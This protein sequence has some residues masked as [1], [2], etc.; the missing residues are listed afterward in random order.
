MQRLKPYRD[1]AKGFSDY[2][3]YAALIDDGIILCKDGSLLAGF[4]Y[5]GPDI[6]SRTMAQREDLS[7]RVHTAFSRLGSGW[8][9][10]IQSIHIETVTYPAPEQSFFPDPISRLVDDERRRQFEAEGQHFESEKSLVIQYTPPLR[11]NRRLMQLV[12][13]DASSSHA[14]MA[15]E[16]IRQFVRDLQNFEDLISDGLHLRRMTSFEVCDAEGRPHLCDELVNHLNYHIDQDT[17]ALII[18]DDGAYLDTVLGVKDF[19]KGPP[20]QLGEHFIACVAIRGFPEQTL[21]QVLYALDQL[22]IPYRWSTRVIHLDRQEAL[23]VLDAYR[24]KWAQRIHGWLAQTFKALRGRVNRDAVDMTEE[25]E[26]SIKIAESGEYSYVYH[27]PLVVLVDKDLEVLSENARKVYRT[28]NHLGFAAWIEGINTAAAWHGSLP[29]H[30]LPNVRRP[31]VHTGNLADLLPLSSVWAG[32]PVHPNPMYPPGSP[33]LMYAAT[34][35]A[36]PFRI[37]LHSGDVAHTLILGPTGSGKSTFLAMIV[38][39]ALRYPS[40]TICCFDKGRSLWAVA[41]ACGGRHYDI[42]ADDTPSFCPLSVLDT[43]ADLAWAEDWIATCFELQYQRP[44]APGERDAIHRG[45]LLLREAGDRTITHFIATVQDEAVRDA[46]RFYSLSGP[47]GYLLDAEEDGLATA[48]LTVNEIEELMAL[49]EQ[50][51]IPTLLLLFRRFERSLHGQPAYLVLDEAWLMLGHPVFRAKIREWLKTMRKANCA[52]ILATQSLSDAFRSGLLDVL[53]ESC[54]TEIYLPN[55][56]A[57]KTGTKD[58]PGP[59]D[60][61]AMMGRNDTEIGLIRTARP[62]RDYYLVSPEGSRMFDLGL[63]PVALA[64]AGVSDKKDIAHLKEL[65]ARHGDEWPFVWLAEKGVEIEHPYRAA[66]E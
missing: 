62:K 16:I 23:D 14:G 61:Y 56:D 11:R 25:A 27:T 33:P 53:V 48:H 32:D 64:F 39:Q 35:G 4:W 40:A 49:K 6:A 1:P 15:D 9:S 29:G 34:T 3:N 18:P 47:M 7:Y 5:R 13:N 12:F 8:A 22:E 43:E 24:R 55:P 20:T 10:W 2:L 54:P 41:N 66:A 50:A 21:P 60:F 51:A 36:T 31:P 44:P 17:P 19:W 42:A 30:V 57:E 65:Q 52:V 63:G 45:M 58:N 37:S 38:L 28:I 59:R 26:R 46:M